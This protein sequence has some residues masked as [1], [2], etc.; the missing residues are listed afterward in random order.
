LVVA[1]PTTTPTTGHSGG[2]ECT[3]GRKQPAGCCAAAAAAFCLIP[4]LIYLERGSPIKRGV[5]RPTTAP[6]A[7]TA[8]GIGAGAAC[9]LFV[10]LCLVLCLS[11]LV[12]TTELNQ[13]APFARFV[14]GMH[15]LS[16][17]MFLGCYRISSILVQALGAGV[18]ALPRMR[19]AVVMTYHL[20][21]VHGRS[22]LAFDGCCCEE[23]PLVLPNPCTR[24][25]PHSASCCDH[26]RSMPF[27]GAVAQ[28]QSYVLVFSIAVVPVGGAKSSV[29]EEGCMQE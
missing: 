14:C 7:T 20:P 21:D 12:L 28:V 9:C 1:G 25:Y 24:R 2:G 23:E 29:Q 16:S 13:P 17:W 15:F 10:R 11:Q 19:A 4:V 6:F 8:L 27:P 3:Q 18:G 22:T 5:T 26:A